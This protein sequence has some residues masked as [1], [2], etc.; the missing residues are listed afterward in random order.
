MTER[1]Y[2][3]SEYRY[4]F[5]GKENDTDFGSNLQDFDARFYSS[6]L[7][8]WFSIDNVVKP[9]LSGY[10]FGR[11]NP[12]IYLDPDGNDDIYFNQ[13]KDGNWTVEIIKC[14]EEK[15]IKFYLQKYNE[16]TGGLLPPERLKL[17]LLDL[18]GWGTY[19]NDWFA[20]RAI[21]NDNWNKYIQES[22]DPFLSG[23]EIRVVT[24]TVDT[25]LLVA[26]LASG[27]LK[28]LLQPD[29]W[30]PSTWM[31]GAKSLSIANL[32][33][34]LREHQLSV[35]FDDLKNYDIA[36]SRGLF[37]GKTQKFAKSVNASYFDDF[38]IKGFAFIGD[39]YDIIRQSI[40]SALSKG[41][42]IHFELSGVDK[43]KDVVS[44]K[45]SRGYTDFELRTIVK[46]SNALKNTNFYMDGK[47]LTQEALTEMGIIFQSK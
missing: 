46:D 6:V 5:N 7:G 28:S 17:G 23:I 40:A 32:G 43:I 24:Q 18:L 33:K 3:N 39:T 35:G 37:E 19:D 29:N 11:L 42:K 13:D 47:K 12:I 10:Q 9:N 30:R 41:G 14:E 36:F 2:S 15:T 21:E 22:N 4:G 1:T 34:F 45:L 31:R 16:N 27:G 25:G 44:G 38:Q 8:K 20:Q 26:D